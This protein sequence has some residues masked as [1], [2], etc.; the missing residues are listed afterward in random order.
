[1]RKKRWY[2]CYVVAGLIGVCVLAIYPARG[3]VPENALA[4]DAVSINAAMAAGSSA[5]VAGVQDSWINNCD[6]D[7]YEALL[8]GQVDPAHKHK[9]RNKL[10]PYADNSVPAVDSPYWAAL[11]IGTVRF[12]PT[13]D[14]ALSGLA[15]KDAAAV[16]IERTC[17][18]YWLGRLAAKGVHAEIA[19]K[20]DYCYQNPLAPANCANPG[21]KCPKSGTRC[22]NPQYGQVVIPT[23]GVYEAA[24]S[25]FLIAYPQVKIIAPWGEP[26]Y[27]PKNE[28]KFTIGGQPGTNFGGASCLPKPQRTAGNCGPL[29]AAQMWVAVRHRCPSC[30]VVAGD[31]GGNPG[32]DK[33]YFGLYSRYL[34]DMSGG[35]KVYHPVVWAIHPY[36]DTTTAEREIA[37]SGRVTRPLNDTL[38]AAFARWLSSWQEK[39]HYHGSTRIWLDEISSF[40]Y[41]DKTSKTC[42]KDGQCVQAAGGRYLFRTLPSA[43]SGTGLRVTRIYYMRFAG[44]TADALIKLPAPATP[45]ISN[46]TPR[47]IY[48]VVVNHPKPAVLASAPS[49]SAAAATTTSNLPAPTR[50]E[51]RNIANNQCLD[52]NDLG[53]TAGQNG[54]KV[55]LWNC[56]GGANQEWTPR[57]KSGQLAWLVNAK[58]PGMCLNADDV[59]GLAN[60]RRVQLWNCYDNANE[61]WNVGTLL[62]NPVSSPLF[63]GRGGS[64]SLA[65]DANKYNLGTRDKVQVWAYY[66]GSSQLWYPDPS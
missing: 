49:T 55:Q 51:I 48:Q 9:I 15:G 24:V 50:F 7:P 2:A 20:P 1:M 5:P 60:G 3:A 54:D 37:K 10:V 34:R 40:L 62:A 38:V 64:Q 29:L 58:Y 56:Y 26:D 17:F 47:S 33:K 39:D 61:L 11:K 41:S 4:A 12:S 45:V 6:N 25:A 19:F 22:P 31:F 52:A 18:N 44:D 46:G 28:P 27:Q 14:I 16:S 21:K 59:G 36:S 43:A 53:P 65:L 63:L 32:Q 42:K 57:Y 66:G 8:P 13:W 23:L 35:S 30:T